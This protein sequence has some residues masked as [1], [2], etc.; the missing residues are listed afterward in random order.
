ME[1]V[2]VVLVHDAVDSPL[3]GA[4]VEEVVVD[5]GLVVFGLF[6]EEGLGGGVGLFLAAGDEGEEAEKEENGIAH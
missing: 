1:L 6:D 4:D 5:A 2:V 3:D